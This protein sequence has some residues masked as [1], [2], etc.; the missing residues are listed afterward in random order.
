MPDRRNSTVGATH[1][2]LFNRYALCAAPGEQGIGYPVPGPDHSVE[3]GR[4]QYNVVWYHPV[5]EA[6]ELP[7]MLTDD[8][9]RY[10]ANGIP[11]ALLSARVRNDMV[12]TGG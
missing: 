1:A 4:R 5:R 9:G 8:Q 11:P 6:D 12:A 3:P 2:L 7:R 10:H